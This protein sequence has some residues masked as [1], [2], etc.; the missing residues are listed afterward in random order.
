MVLGGVKKAVAAA[1][2]AAQ[3]ADLAETGA[4]NSSAQPATAPILRALQR[5]P[6][7]IK[8]LEMLCIGAKNNVAYDDAG[9]STYIR[10]MEAC[11]AAK[12]DMLPAFVPRMAFPPLLSEELGAMRRAQEILDSMADVLEESGGAHPPVEHVRT[13]PHLPVSVEEDTWAPAE[14]IA[15]WGFVA[16]GC[17]T[18]SYKAGAETLRA[19][20]ERFGIPYSLWEMPEVHV[21]TT[22]WGGADVAYSKARTAAVRCKMANLLLR[23]LARFKV[24]VVTIDCDMVTPAHT[25]D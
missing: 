22:P 8:C 14:A 9:I 1:A 7:K 23:G 6:R 11:L 19:S 15:R 21:S 2:T 10:V 20:L 17:Y 13:H 4:L 16:L 24:P 3:L 5:D 12:P 18:S 25:V